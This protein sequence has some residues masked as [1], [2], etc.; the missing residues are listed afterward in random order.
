[1]PAKRSSNR[2]QD[3]LIALAT[4]LEQHTGSGITTAAL[5]AHLGV[6]E[7]ALYRHF[8]SKA[9]MYEALL[10]FVDESVFGL[11]NRITEE[12]Q[13]CDVRVHKIMSL[14]MGFTEKNP[15]I[16]RI[17]FGDVLLGETDRLR[18][19]VE[20]FYDQ[21]GAQLRQVLRQG[22]MNRNFAYP[23]EEIASLLLNVIEGSIARYVRGGFREAP[24]SG[25][26]S[27]WAMLERAVFN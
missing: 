16:A 23:V 21:V 24:L 17:L 5:A 11:I 4:M 7:A 6:S 1:M 13:D 2:K 27:Q 15:G 14:V 8:P 25:W 9:K 3:I 22:A 12:N 26:D 18:A 20:K 19:R 10:D